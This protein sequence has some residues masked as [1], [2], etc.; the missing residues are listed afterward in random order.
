MLQQKRPYSDFFDETL[1]RDVEELLSRF[2]E[3]D[4]VRYADFSPIWREMSFAD[5]FLGIP[6]S[7]ELK[8]FCRVA[9]ATAMK[10]FLPPYSFQIRAGA[11]YL[12]FGLYHSQ[13]AAPPAKLRLALKD[14][15]EVQRFL[16][17]SA[18]SGHHDLVYI[19]EKLVAAR[20]FHYTAMPHV[21]EFQ[22]QKN[23]KKEPVCASF[24]GRASA[25]QD[26]VSSDLLEELRNVQG[27][28]AELK[29]RT[30]EVGSQISVI[31]RD[32][33]SSL[34]TAGQGSCHGSRRSS[35]RTQTTRRG[36][37]QPSSR[38]RLLHSIKK[39]SFQNLQAAPA[40]RRHRQ[41]RVADSS[42]SGAE[43]V[44]EGPKKWQRPPSLRARTWKSLGVTEKTRTQTWL[45]SAPEEWEGRRT[46]AT[47]K[48]PRADS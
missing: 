4:S 45:L 41:T 35:H 16:R 39:K 3:A 22:K 19:Y 31:H 32:L 20:A 27:H 43:Q 30:G 28:Y 14:R 37:E 36:E 42:S 33:V 40:S 11:L 29:E 12:M 48:R 25:V 5:V 8:R 23:P 21:L 18:D 10:Y 24:L 38:A 34:E 7:S 2:Q 26:L 15:A 1:T 6:R 17:D 13:R 9:L 44:P 47:S 46:R